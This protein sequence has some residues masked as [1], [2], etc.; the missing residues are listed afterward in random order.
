MK[1][2]E[3][4]GIGSPKRRKRLFSGQAFLVVRITFPVVSLSGV[5]YSVFQWS[6]L[7][8]VPSAAISAILV[9][10]AIFRDDPQGIYRSL[11]QC[12]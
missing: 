7:S 5:I 6:W 11:I 12:Y 1:I 10:A 2:Y 3:L 8:P 4:C 9:I